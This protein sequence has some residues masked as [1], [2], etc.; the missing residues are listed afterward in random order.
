M[1]SVAI[2]LGWKR[3]ALSKVV[4]SERV[5]AFLKVEDIRYFY[6]LKVNKNE[7]VLKDNIQVISL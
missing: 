5:T 1:Q 3:K 4:K 6:R 7:K 2:L